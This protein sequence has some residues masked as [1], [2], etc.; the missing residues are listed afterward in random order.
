MG[1]GGPENIGLDFGSN[2]DPET[3]VSSCQA[4]GEGDR[5]SDR[6]R[7]DAGVDILERDADAFLSR[8]GSSPSSGHGSSSSMAYWLADR[9]VAGL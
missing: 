3:L 7:A 6:A 5:G 1:R 9:S 2:G 8:K 4:S